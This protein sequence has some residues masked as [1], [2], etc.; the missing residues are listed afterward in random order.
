M[1]VSE[2]NV[3]TTQNKLQHADNQ[4]FDP[5]LEAKLEKERKLR[6]Q[7]FWKSRVSHFG[8]GQGNLTI[9]LLA[10]LCFSTFCYIPLHFTAS[11]DLLL[12]NT[13]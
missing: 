9:T 10:G 6:H 5:E 1:D 12:Y 4:P 3:K 2:K 13:I 7:K 8:E 11:M